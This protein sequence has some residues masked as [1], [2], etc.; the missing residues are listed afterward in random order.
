MEFIYLAFFVSLAGLIIALFFGRLVNRQDNGTSEMQEVANAIR[1]GAKAFLRRQ[2]RTIALLS[3]AL[4]L[5]IFGVYAILGKLDVGTQ[6]GLAFLFG[7]LCSGIAGYTGMAV[8]VRANLKTAAAADKQ[9][10]NKAVQIALRGGAVEGIMVVALALFGLSSLFLVYSWLGFEERSI[11]GLIVGF[12]FGASFVALFAQLGG[13]IYTK[14][15]D[16][17]ADLV[18]KVEAG[19]PEDDP[20]NPAVIADLV[21]DNVGDCAGRGADI[22]EST[23]AENIGAMILGVALF[24]TFGIKGVLFPLVIMAFGLIASII[25]ILV[26]RTRA[27][28]DPM[29]ALNRGYYVTSL[30]SAIAFFFVTREMF[31][32]A[33]T[34]FFLAGLVGIIMSIVFMLLT[35]YYTE[36]KYRPV[37]SIAEA[38]ETGPATNIITGLAV[39]FENTAFPII[40]IAATLFGSYLLGDASGVEQGGLYGTALA[41]M[42]MLVTATYILAMDTFGPITDN[43]GGIVENSGRPEETRKLTDTLDAVGNTTKALTKGYAVGSAALAAFL[44]FSAYIEEVNNLSPDLITA[45]DLSKVPVFIGAMLGAMLIFLFSSLAIRAVGK[46]A[47]AI[48]NEVRRQFREKPGIMNGTEKPDYGQAVD[49]A[50]K[51]ALR[52]MV[53]PGIIAVTVPI[54]VGLIFR[55]E[56]VAGMLMIGTIVG[57]LLA[58]VMNNGG[59]AWDNAK[60][61]IESGKFKDSN[62]NIQ[63]KGS[64]VHAATVIGDTVGDPLKDTAGPSLHVLIKLLATLTLV[65]APLFI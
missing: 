8:S 51:S 5:L 4:A 3:I 2:Y 35:Q 34:W 20:R 25:G 45:V 64:Q 1:Q 48:I 18:G 47:Y 55:A 63:A 38:S 17:G 62:G 60:K 31:G 43:A 32:G 61:F 19:I 46:S 11:P 57:V 59:G 16:V 15:A 9:D 44:L 41:T 50:T 14:A 24:P 52:Q 65:L 30:L 23:A 28:E 53:L 58:I 21:G 12:G 37:R 10:L 33:A 26:V 54:L 27:N 13:G 40:A 42:G 39:A 6:T 22:F 56:A 36:H 7:A 29:K 49:I